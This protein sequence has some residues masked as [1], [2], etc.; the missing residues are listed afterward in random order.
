MIMNVIK[1]LLDASMTASTANPKT[2][3]KHP[4][5]PVMPAF[6]RRDLSST[7]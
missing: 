2:T 6:S 1:Y 7:S 5:K 4:S 3:K